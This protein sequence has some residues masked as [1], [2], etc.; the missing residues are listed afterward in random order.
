MRQAHTISGIFMG[1]AVTLLATQPV[2]ATSTLVTGVQLNPK[3]SEF[4]LVLETEAGD[5]RPQIFSVKRGSEWIADILDTGLSLKE[6]ESFSQQ[7]PIPGIKSV[8]V[9]QIEENSVRVTVSGDENPPTGQILQRKDNLI[10]LGIST[11]ANQ[12]VVD[13]APVFESSTNSEPP[14]AQLPEPAAPSK[15][16]PSTPDQETNQAQTPNAEPVEAETPEATPT[17]PDPAL[18]KPEVLFPNPEI[19]IDGTPAAPAGTVQPVA[20]APPFLPRAVAPPVGDI[21]ISN[22]NATADRIDLGTG[23][24]VPRLVLREAPVREVLALLARAA[25]LNLA[26]TGEQEDPTR[27][28]QGA[29]S[30][31]AAQQTISLDLEDEAVQDVFNYVL[32]ISGLQ[33]NRVGRTIFVGAK[34]PDGARNLV[35]RTLRLNQIAASS[36]ANFLTTQGAETQ[37]PIEQVQIQTVGEGAAARTIEIRTPRILGL[38]PEEGESPLLLKGLSVSTDQRLNAITM[39]GDPRKVEIATSFLIQLDARRRQVAVNVKVVDI[40]LLATDNFN[41]SFT[42]GLNDTLF[43]FDPGSPLTSAFS[44]SQSPANRDAGDFVGSLQ[45]EIISGNGKLLTDPTLVVAEGQVASVNLTQEVVGNIE[46][47]TEGTGDD[48]TT[49]VT[50]E[51]VNVG[52]ELEINI[53]RI[54][55]NGFVTLSVNPKVTSIAD[56]QLLSTGDGDENRITLRN[57]RELA[58]G[59]IRLRDGQTLILAG[60]IQDE[61]RTTVEKVPIL[62]DI[63]ILGA[64][65]RNTNR[66]NRRSEIVVLLTPQILDDSARS[67]FGYNYTP[68]REAREVLDREDFPSGESN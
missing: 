53:E 60:I 30:D 58:S 40:N 38:K 34:L 3:G 17:E 37:I 43:S 49:T 28:A 5:K 23:V 27:A 25:G 11:V 35:S 42:F 10:T 44:L 57:I 50:A 7:N 31:T 45:A 22:I 14:I 67:S 41:T 6:G 12:Q 47:T 59:Q 8:V 56:D 61:N 65:F 26:Y 15:A 4:E 2:W 48:R 36:A 64:L 62:G 13:S 68:G 24:R 33:A 19:T 9:S 32:Q 18:P 55:D 20:P 46:R 21:A 1:G 29:P 54:D 63:P 52:L 51:L 39:V 66:E 16:E